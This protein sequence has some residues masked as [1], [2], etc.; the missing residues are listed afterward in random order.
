MSICNKYSY[1]CVY[2]Q[3]AN[4]LAPDYQYY[5]NWMENSSAMSAIIVLERFF[6][7]MKIHGV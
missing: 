1:V 4:G 6:K 7:S 5:R 3:F 2:N